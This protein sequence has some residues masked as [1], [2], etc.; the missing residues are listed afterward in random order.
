MLTR[1]V[2]LTN[3]IIFKTWRS[4]W[5]IVNFFAFLSETWFHDFH[6]QLKG[7]RGG[8]NELYPVIMPKPQMTFPD[9][10]AIRDRS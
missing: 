2:F 4:T 6:R 3:S 7:M 10:Q 1:L 8:R 5:S 9:L